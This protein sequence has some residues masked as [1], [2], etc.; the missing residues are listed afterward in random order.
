[1]KDD[2]TLTLIFVVD[3]GLQQ[4]ADVV[5]LDIFCGEEINSDSFNDGISLSDDSSASSNTWERRCEEAYPCSDSD[6]SLTEEGSYHDSLGLARTR[7]LR[8]TRRAQRRMSSDSF[9]NDSIE[10]AKMKMARKSM[11]E[12]TNDMQIHSIVYMDDP[13]DGS[14]NDVLSPLVDVKKSPTTSG[15]VA[16][17]DLDTMKPVRITNSAA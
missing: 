3:D 10:I 17:P 7:G 4:T 11:I 2:D 9:A 15:V 5:G 6:D 14:H 12:G 1:M 8:R 16:A 13:R